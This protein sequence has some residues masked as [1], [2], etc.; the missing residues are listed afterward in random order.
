MAFWIRDASLKIGKKTYFLGGLDFSFEVP[1]EDSE[2]PPVATVTVK[3][4]SEN[5]RNGIKK[6]TEVILNAGYEGDVGCILVG[7][8]VGLKHKQSNTDWTTTITVQPCADSIL[9]QQINKTYKKQIKASALVKDLLNIFGVEIGKCELSKNTNYPRGRVCKGKLSNVL[10]DIVVSE[11]KS[12]LLIR[13]T[14]QIYVTKSDDGISNGVVLNTMSGLLRSDDEKEVIPVESKSNSK[15][16][17]EDRNEEDT[18]SRS[19]L[20]N[21]RIAAAEV[22][23]IKSDD[24]N[25]TFIVKSGSHKGGSTGDW[26]TTMELAPYNTPAKKKAEATAKKAAVS[27]ASNRETVKF[28]SRGDSVKT[29]QKALGVSADGI[30]GQETR[31][32]L[33]E[34]QKANGLTANGTCDSATWNSILGG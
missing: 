27:G 21:Y 18:K 12:R 29:L 25:G 22:V 6:N 16:T 24:L 17:G 34:Y 15:K 7:K 13:A 8:V 33:I 32:A 28:G 3:N 2:E 30:F 10:K 1:F 9:N 19:S 11:C 31:S 5:T 23:K 14:G 4:L 26:K 20:L